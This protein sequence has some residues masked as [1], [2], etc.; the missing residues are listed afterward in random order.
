MY[1][2]VTPDIIISK[3]NKHSLRNKGVLQYSVHELLI[4]PEV[5]VETKIQQDPLYQN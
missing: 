4:T 2:E 5:S 3:F 1:S